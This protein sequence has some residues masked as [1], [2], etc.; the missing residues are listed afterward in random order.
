MSSASSRESAGDVGL[1]PIAMLVMVVSVVTVVGI[2]ATDGDPVV[3]LAPV[4][5]ILAL[6]LLARMPLRYPALALL[7][8]GMVLESPAE[9]LANGLFR[10]PIYVIGWL[11]LV[12]WNSVFPVKALVFSGLDLSLIMFFTIASYRRATRSRVDGGGFV[13]T[14]SPLRF[15]GWVTVFGALFV[16][17]WGAVRGN[18]DFGNSLW[19]IE[20]AAYLP[21]F[22][23]AFHYAF[24]GP[25]DQAAVGKTII[26]AATFR[27]GLAWCLR[28]FV[29][30]NSIDL[31]PVATTHSDSLL[32][33]GAFGLCVALLLEIPS[34]K[35]KLLCMVVLPILALGMVA[36]NR[37]IVWVE[38]ALGLAV[39]FFVM[40]MTP[41]K[42]KLIR[43]ALAAVPFIAIYLLVGWDHNGG[44]FGGA[45]VVRSIVDAKSDGSSEWREL[46]NMDLIVS[47]QSSPFF[48]L[49]YGHHYIGPIV[50]QDVYAQEHFLPHNSILGVWAF[51]G[52]FGFTL[53][54]M[55]LAVGAFVACR[56]Y[57]FARRAIDRV[58]ALSL[59]QMLM[60]YMDQCFGDIGLGA[61]TGVL[62]VSV[63]LAMVGKLALTTGAW[64]AKVTTNAGTSAVV[65]R[66]VAS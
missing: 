11:L 32:F 48:G 66:S 64:P 10:S 43:W 39:L 9:P 46:E 17:F 28:H 59:L 45:A 15:F 29:T 7:F 56:T 4:G 14:P 6:C 42:R 52:I 50:I 18:M 55:F 35:N 19:Q 57:K 26:A 60:I 61:T 27:A 1:W 63:G 40:P 47:L 49:G 33:A 13:E 34:A 22:F 8:F 54:W 51:G 16:E 31:M 65:D 25:Q 62:L 20:H 24:R 53:N 41:L 5:A 37:R 2:I 30:P 21:L 58:A 38:I 44:F 36:N 23:F 12:H 3:A